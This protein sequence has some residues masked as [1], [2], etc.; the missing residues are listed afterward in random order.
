MKTRRLLAH[1]TLGV[2]LIL[3]S[4]N[5]ARADRGEPEFAASLGVGTDN[6][7]RGVSQTLGDAAV[8]AY[9]EIAFES[10]LYAYA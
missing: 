6:V 8:E 4:T 7:F 1:G 10:G 9:G 5:H 2:C 3:A